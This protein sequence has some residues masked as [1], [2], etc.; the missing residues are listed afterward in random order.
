MTDSAPVRP[1]GSRSRVPARSCAAKVSRTSSA[2]NPRPGTG[3]CDSTTAPERRSARATCAS[4]TDLPV[5]ASPCTRTERPASRSATRRSTSGST[6]ACCSGSA[7]SC[8]RRAL[9]SAPRASPTSRVHH[10]SASST[11]R[12]C[13][14]SVSF[15]FTSRTRRPLDSIRSSTHSDRRGSAQAIGAGSA[16]H[17]LSVDG[18]SSVG[19]PASTAHACASCSQPSS[20]SST[21]VMRSSGLVSALLSSRSDA[22]TPCARSLRHCASARSGPHSAR[23]CGGSDGTASWSHSGRAALLDITCSA[24]PNENEWSRSVRST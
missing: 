3:T 12:S 4:T 1:V 8:A 21:R 10:S 18:P 20:M 9:T 7:I 11:W 5:P 2:T 24:T 19:Q 17:S 14:T 15:C 16:V 13:R 6:I 22:A 23:P